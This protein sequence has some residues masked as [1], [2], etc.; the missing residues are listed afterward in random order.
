[1]NQIL[2]RLCTIPLLFIVLP[3]SASPG[4]KLYIQKNGV[5][6]RTGPGT[7][8]QVLLKLNKGHELV[9]YSQEGDWINIGIARTGGKTGWVHS[10]LV[11]STSS[12]GTTAAPADRRYD[13]FVRDIE[14]LN[15][16]VSPVSGFPFFTNVESLGD[17]IVLVTAHDRWLAAPLSDRESDLNTLFDLWSEHE[18]SR[19]P[20]AVIIV[21]SRG[22]VVMRKA[23]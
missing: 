21:N 11:T 8:Y 10:S 19:L 16:R 2:I 1:M 7:N 6:I 9:E 14:K 20:I 22:K 5:N 13:A 23:R 18:A 17:G 12:G 4:D 3:V 15:D